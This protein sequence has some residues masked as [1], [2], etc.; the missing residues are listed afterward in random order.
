A[1]VA[2]LADLRTQVRPTNDAIA[3]D[4]L[5]RSGAVRRRRGKEP[6]ASAA[7]VHAADDNRGA[8]AVVT[9]LAALLITG[10][11]GQTAFPVGVA[12]DLPAPKDGIHRAIGAGHE[13]LTTAEGQFVHLAQHE[14]VLAIEVVWPET[15]FGINGIVTPVMIETLGP[16]VM[17]QQGQAMTEALIELSLQGV[18]AAGGAIAE[19]VEILGIGSKQPSGIR[20]QPTFPS[21]SH[22]S[23]I[24]GVEGGVILHE[25]VSAVVADVA[26]LKG[27]GL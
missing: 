26:H 18:V 3:V 16:G 9:I 8:A 1:L 11:E 5:K 13:L 2:E 7:R 17:G 24:V 10:R 4:G 21:E 19:E 15:V 27:H 14:D 23:E 22:D 20:I 6:I 25:A 12:I